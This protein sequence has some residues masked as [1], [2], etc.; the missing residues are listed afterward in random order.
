VIAVVI[1]LVLY[2]NNI[3]SQRQEFQLKCINRQQVLKAEVVNNLNTSYMIQGLLASEPNLTLNDWLEFTN[4]T[5][6]LRPMTPRV[7]YLERV[8]NDNR[9][10][11]ERK[12]NTTMKQMDAQYIQSNRPYNA[13]L[14]YAPII[15]GSTPLL[16]LTFVDLMTFP[17]I[18]RTLQLARSTDSIAMSAPDQYTD[19]WRVGTYLPCFGHV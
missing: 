16:N 2:Y 12:Y 1:G 19:V 15:Y 17:V 18:N 8:T 9:T 10:A 11:W 5:D 7:S 3:E 13:S 14:E 4:S 6:F